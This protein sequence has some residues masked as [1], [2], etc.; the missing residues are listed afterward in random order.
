MLEHFMEQVK[1]LKERGLFV[2]YGVTD[3]EAVLSW[4]DEDNGRNSISLWLDDN[5]GIYSRVKGG[6]ITNKVKF[7][8]SEDFI[9]FSV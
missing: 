4:Y 8:T 1:T 2:S 6:I 7:N 9:N 3:E 5:E